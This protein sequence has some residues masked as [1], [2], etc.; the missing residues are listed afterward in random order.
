[1]FPHTGG[2]PILCFGGFCI[3][4]EEE[5]KKKKIEIVARPVT[6][7]LPSTASFYRLGP[8]VYITG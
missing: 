1:M 6:P 3:A 5:N 7:V 8:W 2:R 4:S